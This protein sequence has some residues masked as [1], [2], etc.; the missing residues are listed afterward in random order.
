MIL[1]LKNIIR[2]DAY[3]CLVDTIQNVITALINLQI[4]SLSM[5]K[6]VFDIVPYLPVLFSSILFWR[7]CAVGIHPKIIIIL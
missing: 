4:K 7:R 2:L 1:C 3:R 6:S 5:T